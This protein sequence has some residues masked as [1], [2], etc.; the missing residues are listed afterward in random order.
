MMLALAGRFAT[1]FWCDCIIRLRGKWC[2]IGR[3]MMNLN[4]WFR[5]LSLSIDL[6]LLSDVTE[7]VL[8]EV[9]VLVLEILLWISCLM[10]LHRVDA[11]LSFLCCGKP[12]H[13]GEWIR[14]VHWLRNVGSGGEV[15]WF[16]A[17]ND[18]DSIAWAPDR[19]QFFNPLERCC[20]FSCST[21]FWLFRLFWDISR[22]KNGKLILKN[23]SDLLNLFVAE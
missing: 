11:L 6:P 22:S 5:C 17:F 14:C 1:P 2:L 16:R 19:V 20:W 12:V 23:G 3:L 4:V 13:S 21:W 8:T 18:V 9:L 10:L 15:C 7:S